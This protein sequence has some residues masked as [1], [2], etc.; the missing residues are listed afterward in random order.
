MLPLSL[1]SNLAGWFGFELRIAFPQA[2]VKYSL[3]FKS[4]KAT[5]Y[6]YYYGFLASSPT[7]GAAPYAM[8]DYVQN[9]QLS[10][11]WQVSL[12][13]VT[14]HIN[15]TMNAPSHSPFRTGRS[16]TT[17]STAHPLGFPPSPPPRPSPS[18][19]TARP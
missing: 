16:S 18:T 14:P 19:S 10:S 11:L 3:Q 5:S 4:P 15:L 17:R 12:G 6:S 9:A 7:P 2:G 1:L 13:E 8:P